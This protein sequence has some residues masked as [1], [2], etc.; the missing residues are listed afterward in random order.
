MTIIDILKVTNGKLIRNFNINKEV[1]PISID[2]RTLKENDVF[3]C[4]K[5]NTFDGHDFIKDAIDKKVSCIIVEKDIG[6]IKSKVPIIKVENTKEA[7]ISLAYF[8]K[9]QY[10][11]YVIAV[12]GS[13]GKTTTKELISKI[14]EKK[15]NVLKNIGNQNNHIGLPLT[16]LKLN[17]EID[18]LV[19]ELGMNH[20]GE[21]HKLSNLVNPDIGVITNIGTSHIGNLGSKK[22]IYEAKLEIVDGMNN[23]YLIVNG[24]DSFLKKRIKKDNINYIRV[25]KKK[26]N[27]LY[28]T[29]IKTTFEGTTFNLLYQKKKY[30]VFFKVPGIHLINNVLLAIKTCLIYGMEMDEIIDALNDFTMLDG[31]MKISTYNNITIINDAYNASFE[32]IKGSID[33][34]NTKKTPKLVILGDVLELGEHSKKIHQKIGKLLNKKNMKVLLVGKEMEIL[35]DKY[36]HFKDNDSLWK[37]IEENNVIISNMTILVKASHSMHLEEIVKKIEEKLRN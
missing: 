9:R 35:K 5:G 27:D 32:S 36:L 3:L 33:L 19:T 37:Y 16:L 8:Y 21:I 24:D 1:G 7:L 13:V 30:K 22:D 17:K 15:Y 14:L 18:I 29:N 4:I 31:R 10:H 34:L 2:S 23:G 11:P 12:T 6:K 20:K 28:C 26:Y 25:G